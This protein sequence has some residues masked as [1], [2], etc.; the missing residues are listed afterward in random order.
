MPEMMPAGGNTEGSA[1]YSCDTTYATDGRPGRLRHVLTVVETTQKKLLLYELYNATKSGTAFT[2]LGAFIWDLTKAYPDNLRGDQ[3]TSADAGGFPMAAL[4][5]TADEVA[6]GAVPHALRFILPNPRMKKLVYVHPG[7][8]AGSPGSTDPNAPP[9]GVR[10]R[11]KATFDETKFNAGE[12][13]ILRAMKTWAHGMLLSDGVHRSRSPSRTTARRRRSGPPSGRDRSV[14][15]GAEGRRLRRRRLARRDRR[16][17]RLRAQPVKAMRALLP[18]RSV[19]VPLVGLLVGLAGGCTT[20]HR[21]A[22]PGDADTFQM[23]ALSHGA[24]GVAVLYPAAVTPEVAGDDARAGG[25]APGLARARFLSVSPTGPIVGMPLGPFQ[26]RLNDVQGFEVRSQLWG[27][28]E[29]GASGALVG[30]VVGA[31]IGYLQGNDPPCSSWCVFQ[32]SATDKAIFSAGSRSVRSAPSWARS[33][34]ASW[35]TPT[36]TSFDRPRRTARR[37]RREFTRSG[38]VSAQRRR[39]SMVARELLHPA[40]MPPASRA[41]LLSLVLLTLGCTTTHHVTRPPS[42]ES[43]EALVISQPGPVAL[44]YPASR[45]PVEPDRVTQEAPATASRKGTASGDFLTVTP[46]G[47]VASLVRG[48]RA[49]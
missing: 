22:R 27:G 2:A 6:A 7:T 9:Y 45:S 34:A 4:L 40:A 48:S 25:R 44:L 36:S 14:L 41:L 38:P 23:L 16:H 26:L 29:G 13:A 32:M 42:L 11:L 10:F 28:L 49:A 21:V 19:V 17:R 24:T 37:I 20:T 35:A 15:R 1:D 5:P 3:C 12:R 39:G 33:L 18:D 8:H 31:G 30:A 46:L 47:P 43:L